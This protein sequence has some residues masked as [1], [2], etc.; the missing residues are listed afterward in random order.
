M[1]LMVMFMV[2]KKN[3]VSESVLELYL[4]YSYGIWGFSSSVL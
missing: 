1:D 4:C 2:A 3:S